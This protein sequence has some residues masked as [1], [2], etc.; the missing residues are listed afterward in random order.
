M[1]APASIPTSPRPSKPARGRHW[2]LKSKLDRS[3]FSAICCGEATSVALADGH[4]ERRLPMK[5][6]FSILLTLAALTIPA[7]LVPW[8][9]VAQTA[10]K[11]DC[12][13][14]Q[15]QADD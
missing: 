5:R 12:K 14:A 9:A 1:R 10:G 15:A 13:T 2:A 3:I 6:F 7:V 11:G 8:P 4:L